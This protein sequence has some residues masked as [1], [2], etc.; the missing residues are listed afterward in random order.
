MMSKTPH[1]G[2]G[3]GHNSLL[4]ML[5]ISVTWPLSVPLLYRLNFSHN[6]DPQAQ[7]A[8]SSESQYGHLNQGQALRP[9][10]CD[11]LCPG[12]AQEAWCL[13]PLW[14]HGSCTCEAGCHASFLSVP[15]ARMLG[16][17]REKWWMNMINYYGLDF[18]K[19]VG[20][21]VKLT[22]GLVFKRMLVWW[23]EWLKKRGQGNGK[24]QGEGRQSR[25]WGRSEEQW[26]EEGEK[27]KEGK[28]AGRDERR[29]RQRR[30]EEPKS[31]IKKMKKGALR[32]FGIY[33]L[34]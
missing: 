28:E 31:R 5:G 30:K 4:V 34:I 16:P 25:K 21:H 13:L 29:T 7:A 6:Y 24:G 20:R 22:V 11:T 14:H 1:R 19:A 3:E 15:K 32:K 9:M 12:S 18:R 2:W 8:L 10:I 17:H 33:F 23:P 26:R 27:W